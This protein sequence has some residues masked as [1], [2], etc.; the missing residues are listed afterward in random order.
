M[1]TK[2][3][4]MG[5]C[6]AAALLVCGGWFVETRASQPVLGHRDAVAAVSPL[7]FVVYSQPPSPAGGLIPSSLRDP[8][9]SVMD[10][11]AWDAFTL[12]PTQDITEI[13]W[14]GGY[15]PARFGSGGPVTDFTVSIY[16][17]IPAGTQPDLSGPPLVQYEVGGN[18]GETAGPVLGG[19]QMYDY[20]F[21]L[22]AAFQA[23]GGTKYWLRIVA[24]QARRFAR[25]GTDQGH[26]GR[27]AVFPPASGRIHLRD[28]DGRYV[29]LVAGA[30]DE[31]PPDVS[32]VCHPIVIM[33]PPGAKS[34]APTPDTKV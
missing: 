11:W 25:L 21:V 12:T 5:V 20:G 9:G 19:V 18:A 27:R 28:D 31:W 22:P 13:R 24:F 32:A 23:L 29:V 30:T 3:F 34:A 10:Q 14:S 6:A 16:A 7:A 2:L 26:R 8:D 1:L 17:S 4:R 33:R 15:D